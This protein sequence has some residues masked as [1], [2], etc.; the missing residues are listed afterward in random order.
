MNKFKNALLIPISL[1]ILFFISPA[2]NGSNMST[3]EWFLGDWIS[4]DGKNITIE[5]WHKVSTETYEGVGKTRSAWSDENIN[6][7]SLRLVEMSGEIFYIAKVEHNEFPIGFKLVTFS[8]S[9]AVFQNLTHDFP[10]RIEYRLLKE[11]RILVT[12][13]DD[14]KQF[15]IDYKKQEK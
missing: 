14:N 7:E 15:T 3:L 2:I 13:S 1:S 11:E 5:F 12:V 9:I 4:D 8:D 6:S 10:K